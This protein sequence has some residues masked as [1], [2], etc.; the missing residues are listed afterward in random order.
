MLEEDW[1]SAG[2]DTGMRGWSGKGI[3][4][5]VTGLETP[6]RCFSKI[7]ALESSMYLF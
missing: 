7:D 5:V 1:R 4:E 3:G 6:D 2:L